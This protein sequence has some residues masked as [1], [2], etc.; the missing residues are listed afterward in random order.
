MGF[1][2]WR[3]GIAPFS[4]RAFGTRRVAPLIQALPS[5][6]IQIW[7]WR[8]A[9][10]PGI[11]K[12]RQ[13][14]CRE[15][16]PLGLNRRLWVVPWLTN[17]KYAASIKTNPIGIWTAIPNSSFKRQFHNAKIAPYWTTARSGRIRL[18]PPLKGAYPTLCPGPVSYPPETIRYK[19][20]Y[21]KN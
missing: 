14:L 5:V 8:S 19:S 6:L 20:T 7:S 3:A 18:G 13:R 15:A 2:C 11:R 4:C 12:P 1:L 17:Q 9:D 10:A 21:R 16:G